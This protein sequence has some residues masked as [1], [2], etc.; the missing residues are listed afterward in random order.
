MTTIIDLPEQLRSPLSSPWIFLPTEISC[1]ILGKINR[2]YWAFFG[3][4]C[5]QFQYVVR[6]LR[7]IKYPKVNAWR[8]FVRNGH[9]ELIS[10][11]IDCH[12]K[13]NIKKLAK[14]ATVY[15]QIEILEMI[16]ANYRYVPDERV[17]K[18]AARC[19]HIDVL[20]WARKNNCEWDYDTCAMAAQNGHLEVLIWARKN[21]CKWNH[22]VCA[23]AAL[24]GHLEVLIWA[25]KNG[26]KWNY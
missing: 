11:M 16:I 9:D 7:N 23:D 2:P 4:T 20:K 10:F 3:Q 14:Y 18:I 8:I 6:C 22:G 12:Y 24:N 25:R 19:G 26:C 5:W 21:G 15:G 13:Y 1:Y 17:I